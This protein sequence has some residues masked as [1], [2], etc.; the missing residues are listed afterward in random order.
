MTLTDAEY[1]CPWHNI[2]IPKKSYCEKCQRDFETR[3]DA[4]RMTVEERAMA[5]EEIIEKAIVTM[6][7]GQI[8]QRIEELVGRPVWTHELA[9]KERCA[10]LVAEIRSGNQASINDVFDKIPADNKVIV[11]IE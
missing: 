10:M 7:F 2:S 4:K 3:K 11:V 1:M 5:L 8:H 6:P 9:G